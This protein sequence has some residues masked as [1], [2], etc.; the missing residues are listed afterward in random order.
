MQQ[1]YQYC[2]LIQ[3]IKNLIQ[4]MASRNFEYEIS[5]SAERQRKAKKTLS[6]W[7]FAAK[8]CDFP[9]NKGSIHSHERE[10][11]ERQQ[12]LSALEMQLSVQRP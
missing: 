9:C 7:H 5:E 2:S 10:R 11:Q 6:G 12:E 4:N 1:R 3:L 8:V